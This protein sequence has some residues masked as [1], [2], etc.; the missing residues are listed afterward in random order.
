M[1]IICRGCNKDSHYGGNSGASVGTIVKNTGY[2]PVM[3]HAGDLHYLCVTCA[4]KVKNLAKQI[5]DIVKDEN[6]YFP[7]LLR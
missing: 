3:S 1:T 2:S 5:N 7:N 4:L 6:L